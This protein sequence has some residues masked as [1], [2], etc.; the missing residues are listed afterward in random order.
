MKEKKKQTDQPHQDVA[1]K[2]TASS[3]FEQCDI[4]VSTSPDHDVTDELYEHLR[5]ECYRRAD[6]STSAPIK[7]MLRQ[8]YGQRYFYFSL[9]FC[10][11]K[12]KFPF[13]DR[14]FCRYSHEK[15]QAKANFMSTLTI[16]WPVFLRGEYILVEFLSS[17]GEKDAFVTTLHKRCS[18]FLRAVGTVRK[19]HREVFLQILSFGCSGF[20]SF[21]NDTVFLISGFVSREVV[22]GKSEKSF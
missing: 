15:L 2:S 4:E 8:T 21:R 1:S 10:I 3:I 11:Y 22:C 18:S 5:E 16:R 6:E 14:L 12:Y 19:S 9:N 13:H 7:G 20:L 17:I